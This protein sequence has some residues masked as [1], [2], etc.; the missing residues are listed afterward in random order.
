MLFAVKKEDVTA[1]KYDLRKAGIKCDGITIA[2]MALYN[3]VRFEMDIP[4][5]CIVLDVGADH[6][7]LVVMMEGNRFFVRRS[8][9]WS[10]VLLKIHSRITP[11]EEAI[12]KRTR[13]RVMR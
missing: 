13:N 3:F 8:F 5:N 9:R 7:D 1:L 6:T 2:P 4:E 11:T 10:E 12:R